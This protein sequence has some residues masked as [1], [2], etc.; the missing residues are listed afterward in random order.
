MRVAA[1]QVQADAAVV[2]EGERHFR[3]RQCDAPEG[4]GAMCELGILGLEE[5]SPRWRVVVQVAHLDDGA[6][7]QGGWLRRRAGFAAEPPG[8]RRRRSAAGVRST[9]Q[10]HTGDGGDR[11]QRLAAEAKRAD[12]FEVVE[13]GDLRRCVSHE[14]QRQFVGGDSAAVVT[15]PDQLDAAFL[16]LDLD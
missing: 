16:E 13:R 10:C 12:P 9:R 11:S 5:L 4:L 3:M 2:G 14:C 7:C 1:R 15:D 6:G 8:V